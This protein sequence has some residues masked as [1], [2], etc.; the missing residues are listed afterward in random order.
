MDVFI[1]LTHKVQIDDEQRALLDADQW[2][3]RDENS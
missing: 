2:S 3:S 1:V